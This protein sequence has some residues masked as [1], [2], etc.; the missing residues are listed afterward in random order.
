MI[1]YGQVIG[2]QEG[3]VRLFP[4]LLLLLGAVLVAVSVV[5]RLSGREAGLAAALICG[6]GIIHVVQGHWFVAVLSLPLAFAAVVIS[7]MSGT[8]RL[9][10][11]DEAHSVEAAI[12]DLEKN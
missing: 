1:D 9:L 12:R 8:E 4:H 7:L 3:I 10:K 2:A 6:F 5:R 11:P